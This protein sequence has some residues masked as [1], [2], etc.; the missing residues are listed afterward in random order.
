MS[1]MNEKVAGKGEGREGKAAVFL[2][3]TK[4][5]GDAGE[6]GALTGVFVPALYHDG[7]DVLW[8]AVRRVHSVASIHTSSNL[9]NWLWE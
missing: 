4:V 9:L 2:L 5:F 1:G 3:W 6:V 7:V 8:A